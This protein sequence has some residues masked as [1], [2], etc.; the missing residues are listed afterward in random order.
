MLMTFMDILYRWFCQYHF[1]WVF[2]LA[3]YPEVCSLHLAVQSNTT[4]FLVVTKKERV[5]ALEQNLGGYHTAC[6]PNNCFV[7]IFAFCVCYVSVD[8]VYCSSHVLISVSAML[9]V[10]KKYLKYDP[11]RLQLILT[12]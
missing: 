12:H 7:I 9:H 2:R 6:D 5:V 11:I 10:G 8:F 4:M 1:L 3:Y